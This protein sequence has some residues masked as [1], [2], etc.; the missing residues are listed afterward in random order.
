MQNMV[1][2]TCDQTLPFAAKINDVTPMQVA[3]KVSG[4]MFPASR[5][6]PIT[7]DNE[8]SHNVHSCFVKVF[9]GL[10]IITSFFP[11]RKKKWYSGIFTEYHPAHWESFQSLYENYSNIIS[12]RLQAEFT[13]YYLTVFFRLSELDIPSIIIFTQVSMPKL[14]FMV[15]S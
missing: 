7:A 6:E 10:H 12:F 13:A 3:A 4:S 14:L 5:L 11:K 15:K 2:K 9:I 1:I 8:P